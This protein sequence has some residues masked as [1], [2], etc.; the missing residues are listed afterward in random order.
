MQ[1][2]NRYLL[3]NLGVIA[4]LFGITFYASADM[5]QP[6]DTNMADMTMESASAA[7]V[8]D[9]I[10]TDITTTFG[11]M[12]LNVLAI[13]RPKILCEEGTYLEKCGN[14]T[15]GFNWLK[16]ININNTPTR[17]YYDAAATISKKYEKMREVFSSTGNVSATF[18]DNFAL[19]NP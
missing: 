17:N 9:S 19:L 16:S 13:F 3:K 8:E 7:R 15:I 12:S 14:E 5:V 4:I 11:T 1:H 10:G 6:G 2:N 18:K